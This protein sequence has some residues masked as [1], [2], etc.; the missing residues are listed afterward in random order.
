MV[1]NH[2]VKHNGVVY[3][4]G[5]DV[6]VGNNAEPKEIKV[7]EVKT[8]VKPEVKPTKTKITKRTKK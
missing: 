7:E 6:P 3:P 1:F 5:A 2:R 8:E 4:A